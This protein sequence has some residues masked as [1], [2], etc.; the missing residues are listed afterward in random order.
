MTPGAAIPPLPVSHPAGCGT[1]GAR[2]KLLFID[3][4]AQAFIHHRSALARAALAAGYDVHVAVPDDPCADVAREMGLI[5]HRSPICRGNRSMASEL[6]A[7]WATLL[8]S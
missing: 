5:V 3:I 7:A 2:K 4:D 8:T 6:A 1:A